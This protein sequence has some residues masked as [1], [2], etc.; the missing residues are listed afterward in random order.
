MKNEN[1]YKNCAS[2]ICKTTHIDFFD[3]CFLLL[4]KNIVLKIIILF[5]LGLNTLYIDTILIVLLTIKK[6]H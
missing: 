1:L 6:P 3:H 2:F 5:T 4:G